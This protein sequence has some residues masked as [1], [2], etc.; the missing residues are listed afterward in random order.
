ML[1][2]ANFPNWTGKNDDKETLVSPGSQMKLDDWLR[3]LYRYFL[4]CS[5]LVS[6]RCFVETHSAWFIWR[7]PGKLLHLHRVPL[8]IRWERC[9]A[10]IIHFLLQRVHFQK[11]NINSS[12]PV[13]FDFFVSDRYII[14]YNFLGLFCFE[15]FRCYRH[16]KTWM[17]TK[18]KMHKNQTNS[19]SST[20]TDY[21]AKWAQSRRTASSW[22][23]HGPFAEVAT[24]AF[25][26]FADSELVPMWYHRNGK[27]FPLRCGTTIAGQ[28]KNAMASGEIA[29]K[30]P[31]VEKYENGE[32]R[33][34]D[35]AENTKAAL[36][37]VCVCVC[38]CFNQ[39]NLLEKITPNQ[40]PFF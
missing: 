18:N 19:T 14:N 15:P 23:C 2:V 32:R 17:E 10:V 40:I 12:F 7:K 9:N 38:V 31:P 4:H 8:I 35:A 13:T 27:R 30:S 29:A 11:T 6:L 1:Q 33:F 28:D 3:Y 25:F 26:L 37:C 20:L 16:V 34:G 22:R 39:P 24:D 5:W 36:L 21:F